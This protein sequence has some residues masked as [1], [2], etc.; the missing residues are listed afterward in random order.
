M[1]IFATD[2]IF[3]RTFMRPPCFIVKYAS[4][5]CP[6]VLLRFRFRFLFLHYFSATRPFP[7][8]G[9]SKIRISLSPP[10][11]RIFTV[12]AITRRMDLCSEFHLNGNN[13]GF[14]NVLRAFKE[15]AQAAFYHFDI[16]FFSI[17]IRPCDRSHRAV[18]LDSVFRF[19]KVRER[20]RGA[21]ISAKYANACSSFVFSPLLR[22]SRLGIRP[23]ALGYPPSGSVNA[24]ILSPR[25]SYLLGK[26]A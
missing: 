26:Y 15:R 18:R 16:L 17:F 4:D 20:L 12:F 8:K 10:C 25:L 14:P 9:N 3:M 2:R 7:D 19:R 11:R 5:L 13:R 22:Y 1:P 24:A 21:L 6:N 23:Q